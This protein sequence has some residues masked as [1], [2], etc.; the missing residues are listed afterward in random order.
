MTVGEM[1]KL[2][3]TIFPHAQVGLDNDGQIVVYTGMEVRHGWVMPMQAN[4]EM[5]A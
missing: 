3:E 5:E 4:N 1:N 2:I